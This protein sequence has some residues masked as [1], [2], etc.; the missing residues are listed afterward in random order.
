MYQP[1]CCQRVIFA[2]QS[3][4]SSGQLTRQASKPLL[5][6]ILVTELGTRD[7]DDSAA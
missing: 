1:Q 7:M 6:Y 3:K 4:A 5:Y 2:V